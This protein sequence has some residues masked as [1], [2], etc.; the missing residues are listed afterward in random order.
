MQFDQKWCL[1]SDNAIEGIA[2]NFMRR[3]SC[4]AERLGLFYHLSMAKR[5]FT[6]YLFVYLTVVTAACFAAK[7][8][9]LSQ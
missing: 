4:A 9:R 8:W 1:G 6:I 2:D 7:G 3:F 5:Y